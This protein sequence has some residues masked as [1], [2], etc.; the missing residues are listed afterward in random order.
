MD[1][2]H[3]SMK[4]GGH[5]LSLGFSSSVF[6]QLNLLDLHRKNASVTGV[7][8][9]GQDRKDVVNALEM[10]I[11]MFDDNLLSGIKIRPYPLDEI[12]K[13]FEDVQDPKFFGK[14][15]ITMY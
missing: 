12:N 11:K 5:L 3:F 10:I 2:F 14:A 1:F 9:H 4:D 6:P 15:V 13:C 8:F 7:W